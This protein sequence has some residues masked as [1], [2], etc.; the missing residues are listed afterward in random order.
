MTVSYVIGITLSSWAE[1]IWIDRQNGERCPDSEGLNLAQPS[2][3]PSPYD[4]VPQLRIRCVI[5]RRGEDYQE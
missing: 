3:G 1:T 5:H 2:T 4:T